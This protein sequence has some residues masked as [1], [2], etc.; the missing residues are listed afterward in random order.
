MEGKVPLKLVSRR[1]SRFC[2][3]CW[4]HKTAP[5]AQPTTAART[6]LL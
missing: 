6:S 5:D 4:W 1:S 2:R 3:S